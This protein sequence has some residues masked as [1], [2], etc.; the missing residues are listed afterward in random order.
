MTVKGYVEILGSAKEDAPACPWLSS[1]PGECTK[2]TT[3]QHI[4][5]QL[6]WQ[7]T[8][9]GC[10]GISPGLSR[11]L[12]RQQKSPIR[13]TQPLNCVWLLWL[14]AGG[15]QFNDQDHWSHKRELLDRS[16]C[17]HSSGSYVRSHP[18]QMTSLTN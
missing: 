4:W 17:P 18:V 9:Q 8:H 7:K 1:I 6:I 15:R 13:V 5:I 3:L 14:G 10:I 12:Y 11:E 2:A 16:F